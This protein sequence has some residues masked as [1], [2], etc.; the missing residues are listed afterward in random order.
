MIPKLGHIRPVLHRPL[1]GKIK[2]AV[3]SK[4]PTGEYYISVLTD[5]GK[6]AP[7]KAPITEESAIGIDL[8]IKNYVAFSNGENIDN[9][10]YLDKSIE[11]I[12]KTINNS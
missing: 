2:S 10:K 6:P 9:P 1:E 5:D 3:I 8:G 11:K 7:D 12:K 4:T